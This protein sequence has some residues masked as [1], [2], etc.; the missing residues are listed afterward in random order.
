[1]DV[2]IPSEILDRL[3]TFGELLRYLLENQRTAPQFI[4]AC[5]FFWPGLR[6]ARSV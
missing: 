1:M 2:A 4:L 3:T 5:L 6:A